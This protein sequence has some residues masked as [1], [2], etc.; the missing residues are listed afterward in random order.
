MSCIV[1]IKTASYL[2]LRPPEGAP[3]NFWAVRDPMPPMIKDGWLGE[4]HP[5][6][7]RHQEKPLSRIFEEA[8]DGDPS[9]FASMVS[10]L[11]DI[12]EVQNGRLDAIRERLDLALSAPRGHR[13]F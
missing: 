11:I 9:F 13:G 5:F 6:Q 3:E 12:D 4:D 10:L 8:E 1:R 2:R 7:E